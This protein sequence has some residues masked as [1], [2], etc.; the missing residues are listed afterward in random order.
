MKAF[1]CDRCGKVVKV[2]DSD[3][4]KNHNYLKL[5]LRMDISPICYDICSDCGK[6]FRSEFLNGHGFKNGT[7]EEQI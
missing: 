1:I 5:Y 4:Y 3:N 2:N 6:A 7:K